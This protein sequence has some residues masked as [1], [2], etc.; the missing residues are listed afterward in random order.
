MMGEADQFCKQVLGEEVPRLA[1]GDALSFEVPAES[2]LVEVRPDGLLRVLD[3]ARL[4]SLPAP[5]SL[6]QPF[7][8]ALVE[9]KMQGDH[10]DQSALERLLLR[11]QVRQVQRV[12][13]PARP[14]TVQAA[15]WLVAAHVPEWLVGS[16]WRPRQ[17]AEGV[18]ELASSTFSLL[19]VASNELELRQEHVSLLV[20]RRGR[21]LRA[22]ALWAAENRRV[23]WVVRMLDLVTMP[24][25]LKEEVMRYLPPTDDPER[26]ALRLRL[27][28]VAVEATPGLKESF[29]DE[30]KRL[31]VDEGRR[32]EARRAVRRVLEKR[33]LSLS[34]A[35]SATLAGC[36]DLA[37]L[38]RW[39]E[40]AITAATVDEA[41][42]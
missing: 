31:G 24:T 21:A 38:E 25:S 9:V 36:A 7:D 15:A 17:V 10:L 32:A 30:G 18:Y 14:S 8:E 34:D 28:R 39:H 6:L 13:D 4:A 16:P 22:F 3:A 26:I 19:W 2:P 27:L 5:W 20:T 41:L 40:Q 23:D 33:G 1:G 37:F 12:E 29:L 35:Q 42:A 11:R